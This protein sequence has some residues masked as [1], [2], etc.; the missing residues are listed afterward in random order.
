MSM[1]TEARDRSW[2]ERPW[3]SGRRAGGALVL[4]AASTLAGSVQPEPQHPFVPGQAE[5]CSSPRRAGP[6]VQRD[7]EGLQ[8]TAF[9]E[10]AP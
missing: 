6:T 9:E 5:L 7:L 2:R 3:R 10:L 1:R 8:R 4:C